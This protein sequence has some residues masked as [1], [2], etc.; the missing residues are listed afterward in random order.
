MELHGIVGFAIQ[1]F[2]DNTPAQG[3]AYDDNLVD[4]ERVSGL[5]AALE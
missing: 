3:W 5:D 2:C 4:E 1:V